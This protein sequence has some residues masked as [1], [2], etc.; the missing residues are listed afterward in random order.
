MQALNP[1]ADFTKA[2]TVLVVAQTGAPALAK[3]QV[4]HIEVSKAKGEV[5]A[6]AADGSVLAVYPATV[7]S[8]ER[9]SP[10]GVHK[11]NG[12]AYNP[13][14]IYDPA[15]LHWG[16][17]G[18]GKLRIKPGPKGPVGV[19][20]IDLNAPSYGIH[21]SPD[22]TLIGKTASHGCVRLTNWDAEALAHGVKPGVKVVFE[23]GGQ[24]V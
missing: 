17:Q 6:F 20:W 23:G 21:G 9:P 3:G 10:S 16:P 22:P 15:K 2:G 13:D 4:D 24:G 12:V 5:I 18:H 1:H 7:G 14:Y 19:V 8:T 11:V